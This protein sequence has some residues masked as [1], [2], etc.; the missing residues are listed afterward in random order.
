[1]KV[2][3][4][5]QNRRGVL[6]G[7]VVCTALLSAAGSVKSGA[8]SDLQLPRTVLPVILLAAAAAA[9]GIVVGLVLRKRKASKGEHCH[10]R[11]HP[12]HTAACPDR[13]AHWKNQLDGFLEAGLID[14][15]EYKVL[16]ERYTRETQS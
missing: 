2:P 8:L 3:T 14:K 1:M 13:M 10:D 6:A 15:A 11:L 9:V 16:M 5:K 12:E 4:Q 7:V